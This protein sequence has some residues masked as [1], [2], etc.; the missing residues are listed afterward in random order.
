MIISYR[1]TPPEQG[2]VDNIWTLS[3]EG[4]KSTFLPTLPIHSR[5]RLSLLVHDRGAVA[6]LGPRNKLSS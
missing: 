5:R 6:G 2:A 3:V 4:D 1:F